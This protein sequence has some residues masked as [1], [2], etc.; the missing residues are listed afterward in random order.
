[1]ATDSSGIIA[2]GG[3]LGGRGD[4]GL[5]AAIGYNVIAATTSAYI[6]SSTIDVNG[7]V[8]VTATDTAVIGSATI[9]VGVTTGSGGL[10]GAGSVSINE[11]TDTTD[12]HISNTLNTSSSVTSGG[13]TTVTATDHST[14]GSVAGASEGAAVGA[15][16]SYNLIQNSILAYVDDS[17]VTTG[18][19]LDLSGTSS[20]ILV[21]IAVGAAGS[22]DGFALGGSITV[23]SI[24][25]DVDT[26]ISDSTID[27]QG[28]VALQAVESAVMVVLAGG[29]AIS[30]GG[31]AFGASIAYNY[32]GGSFNPTNP[33][34]MNK[35]STTTNQQVSAT[36]TNSKVTA[37][38]NVSVEASFGPPPDLPGSNDLLDFGYTSVTIPVNINSMLVS[39]TVG[40]AGA[41]GFALGGSVNLN[42]LRESV[43]ASISS[44]TPADGQ[45]T[46]GGV[47]TVSATDSS[48]LGAGAGALAIS[49]T[50]GAVGAAISTNDVAN[51]IAAGISGATVT[52]ASVYVIS[53]ESATI[54]NITVAGSGAADFAVG[55]SVSVNLIANNV[56]ASISGG[57]DV[58]ATSTVA[59]TAS[60]TA[61]IDSFSGQGSFAASGVGAG[62]AVGFNDVA[63][64]VT[65]YVSGASTSVTSSGSDVLIQADSTPTIM[66]FTGGLAIGTVAGLAGS[67]S[68]D[69]MGCDT[70]AYIDAATVT[71]DGS[72]YLLADTADTVLTYAG[73]ISGSAGVGVGGTVAVN[74]LANT[75]KARIDDGANVVSQGL[76]DATIGVPQWATDANGTESTQQVEGVVVIATDTETL[77][78]LAITGAV[79]V[80]AAGI[81]LNIAVD[82]FNDTTDAH[83]AGSTVTSGVASGGAVIVRAHRSTGITSAGGVLGGGVA[84]AGSGAGVAADIDSSTTVASINAATVSAGSGGVEVSALTRETVGTT[85][86]GLGVGLYA[87]VAGG[88][89]AADVTTATEAYITDGSTVDSDGNL[90]VLANSGVTVT[91]SD[92][93]L[94]A[95]A[96]GGG[97]GIAVGLI[98]QTTLAQIDASTT[99]ASGLTDVEADSTET[100]NSTAV[101]AGGGIVGIAGAIAVVSLSS[102][103]SASIVDSN[104]NQDSSYAVS[105]QNVEVLANDT[106]SVT[107]R[108]GS[109][110]IGAVAAGAGIDVIS[111]ENTVDANISGSSKVSAMGNVQVLATAT[112]N[113][114]STAFS[115]AVSGAVSLNGTVSV[116]GIGSG[117]DSKGLSQLNSI[118][119]TVD[120]SIS[121]SGGVPGVSQSSLPGPDPSNPGQDATTATTTPALNVDGVLVANTPPAATQAYI[122]GT[123]VIVAGGGVTVSATETLPSVTALVGQGSGGIVSVGGSVA[124]ITVAPAVLAFLGDGV[125]VTAGGDVAVSA[126]FTDNLTGKTYAGT[127]GY[128]GLGAQVT[129]ITDNASEDAFI[130]GASVAGASSFSVTATATR[131]DDAEAA[132]G[133][134]GVVAAGAAIAQTTLGGSTTAAI[135]TATSG[136][137]IGTQAGSPVGAVTVQATST[138]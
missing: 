92:G 14:I 103:T 56:S 106:A 69:I 31:A 94:G 72:V 96:V 49:P 21:A 34:V 3:A 118:Q 71:A 90:T 9:G 48:T 63:D 19:D 47:V 50:A 76:D 44:D 36:I 89:S 20:P 83:I 125:S 17:T 129:Y 126:T 65:A 109:A 13:S 22:G 59:V 95:G 6:D 64:T 122:S 111:V 85:T 54:I 86:V 107:D 102:A 66:T 100:V 43:N 136:A 28:S 7:T 120:S 77:G 35:P 98:G 12:A 137:Q 70:E 117:L 1:E 23:N 33:N 124:T 53:G 128:I 67:V 84:G 16:I 116:I 138:D 26:H 61:T 32:I 55:G 81:G 38:Q 101:A 24:A 62:V 133:T 93:V 27:A 5:G 51:T 130:G 78:D 134:F 45:V 132:G 88:A 74:D 4:V 91:P 8:T 29:I 127:A 15:A 68:I 99:N 40:G 79:G 52:A 104:V 108:I 60:D 30:L 75:T 46:A 82:V 80:G 105:G 131:N 41:D 97:G 58:T 73:T 110:A 39:V 115:F 18:G 135:G 119:T 121:L 113:V 2:I 42:F 37:G 25:N 112:D 11:I 87:G 10:A 114:S 57:A 123:A